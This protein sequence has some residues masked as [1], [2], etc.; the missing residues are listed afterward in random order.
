MKEVFTRSFWE[1][2]KKTFEEAREGPR[3]ADKAFEAPPE[4]HLDA[5]TS[6]DPSSP[7]PNGQG[8]GVQ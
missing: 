3:P 4:S 7:H 5:S 8:N 2:V 6:E 1:G